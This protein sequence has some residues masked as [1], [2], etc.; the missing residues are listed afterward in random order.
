[1]RAHLLKR[2]F[3]GIATIM[4]MAAALG[5][6]SASQESATG[7]NQVLEWNQ[8]FVD[9]LVATNTPNSSSQRLGAIVHTAIF[10]A[11]N[12]VERR[13]TPIFVSNTAPPGASRRAAVIAAA[14]TA[15]LSLFPSRQTELD[16][17]YAASI[18]ALSD[19]GGDGGKSRERGIAWGIEVAS[20]S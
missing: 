2:L 19:D 9:T 14:Y 18:E 3:A 10:D 11:Y 8:I 13:F 7:S 15:L 16:T 4:A 1:M 5:L 12:G 6:A 20:A 17:S